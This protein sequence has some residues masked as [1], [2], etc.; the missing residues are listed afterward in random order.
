MASS[1]KK[2]VPGYHFKMAEC[3]DDLTWPCGLLLRYRAH[4]WWAL[5]GTDATARSE[6]AGLLVCLCTRARSPRACSRLHAWHRGVP[7]P[8]CLAQNFVFQKGW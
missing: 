8:S 2:R 4:S 3:Q 7:S 6:Y 1:D 5:V